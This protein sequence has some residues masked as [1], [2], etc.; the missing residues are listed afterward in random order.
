MRSS[1]SGWKSR[2]FWFGVVASIAL[3]AGGG[4]GRPVGLVYLAGGALILLV[5]NTRLRNYVK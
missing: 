3:V 1:Y 4:Y 5:E 2:A